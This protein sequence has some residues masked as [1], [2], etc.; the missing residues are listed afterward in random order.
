MLE[1]LDKAQIDP[2]NLYK[3]EITKV[4]DSDLISFAVGYRKGAL[5][6]HMHIL[7]GKRGGMRH[8]ES[9]YAGGTDYKADYD[10]VSRAWRSV[11]RHLRRFP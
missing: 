9:D 5:R 10:K 8:G 1:N 11:N 3:L 6:G 7:I 4:D 2:E